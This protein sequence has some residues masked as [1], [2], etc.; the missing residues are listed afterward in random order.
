M[1][2]SDPLGRARLQWE[3]MLLNRADGGHVPH[4]FTLGWGKGRKKKFLLEQK[5]LEYY[6]DCSQ[7]FMEFGGEVET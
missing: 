1:R 6:H 5:L 2:S 3:E 4:A 7:I